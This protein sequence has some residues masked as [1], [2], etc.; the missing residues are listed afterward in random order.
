MYNTEINLR[1]L[2]FEDMIWITYAVVCFINIYGNRQSKN[3]FITGNE[4][5]KDNSNRI[6]EVTFIIVFFIYSYFLL[7]NYNDYKNASMEEK[8]LYFIRFLGA[9]FLVSAA[10]CLI[11]FQTKQLEHVG[12]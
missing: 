2:N 11:Y 4:Y 7:R 12:H 1:R 6:F 5:Y 9:V 10:I 8:Q 3:Y